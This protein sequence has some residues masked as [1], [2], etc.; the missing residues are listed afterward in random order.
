MC[1]SNENNIHNCILYLIEKFKKNNINYIKMKFNKFRCSKNGNNCEIEI[2]QI[3]NCIE[4]NYENLFYY[5]INCKK[6][7][8]LSYRS[9][10][11]V[12]FE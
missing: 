8:F 3:D 10:V 2:Y 12:L 6:D 11:K 4:K 1:I 9:F 5:K 7:S